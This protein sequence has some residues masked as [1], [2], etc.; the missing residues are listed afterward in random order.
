[1]IQRG[2]IYERFDIG[3]RLPFS[4]HDSIEFAQVEI[5]PS[6]QSEDGSVFGAQGDQSS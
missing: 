4:L 3:A 5:K 6:G 2:G 1:M